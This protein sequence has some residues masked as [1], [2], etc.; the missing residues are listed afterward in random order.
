MALSTAG[1]D[2]KNAR[3]GPGLALVSSRGSEDGSVG[4]SK[5]LKSREMEVRAEQCRK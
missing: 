5:Q 4:Y 2:E 3:V 1:G